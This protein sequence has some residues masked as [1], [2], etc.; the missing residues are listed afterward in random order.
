MADDVVSAGWAMVEHFERVDGD[1]Q[2]KEVVRRMTDALAKPRNLMNESVAESLLRQLF[3][4]DVQV[5]VAGN[6]ITCER[7]ERRIQDFFSWKNQ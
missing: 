1:E 5:M 7:L 6:P 3:E 2:H 4:G